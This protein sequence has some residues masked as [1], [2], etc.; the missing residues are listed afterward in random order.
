LLWIPLNIIL[1]NFTTERRLISLF[2][3]TSITDFIIDKQTLKASPY[4]AKRGYLVRIVTCM[5]LLGHSIPP[6]LEFSRRK[7]ELNVDEW[8]TGVWYL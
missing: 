3:N 1:K 5:V 4:S 6:L 7:H 2:Y 8:H